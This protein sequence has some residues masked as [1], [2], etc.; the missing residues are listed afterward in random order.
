MVQLERP[1]CA[2]RALREKIDEKISQSGR[3]Q[4]VY[5]ERRWLCRQMVEITEE[6]E[7]DHA[8]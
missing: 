6:E 8:R 7:I 2:A 4:A 1:A 5:G 3:V